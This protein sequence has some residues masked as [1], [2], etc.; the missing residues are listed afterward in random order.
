VDCSQS[1]LLVVLKMQQLSLSSELEVVEA[2]LRWLQPRLG[3]PPF[4]PKRARD[5]LGPCLEQIRFLAL[6]PSQF[7]QHVTNSGLLSTEDCLSVLVNITA[8]GQ[9]PLPD[10]VCK[11]SNQR[12]E[13]QTAS[14]GKEEKNSKSFE[15][16]KNFAAQKP[17]TPKEE[18]SDSESEVCFSN[19][20]SFDRVLKSLKRS[21]KF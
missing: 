15:K 5:L 1:S 13:K 4:D 20:D 3:N 8:A 2:V 16:Q 18:D 9:M 14:G 6:S 7:S 19:L 17:E 11:S 10:F 21:L 12:R